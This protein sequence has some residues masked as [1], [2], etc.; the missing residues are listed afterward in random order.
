[1]MGGVAFC[2]AVLYRY[3]GSVFGIRKPKYALWLGRGRRRRA[4]LFLRGLLRG[5]KGLQKL[6]RC[7]LGLRR[8]QVD[9]N[10][11]NIGPKHGGS[12]FLRSVCVIG[13][14]GCIR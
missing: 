13:C 3:T 11:I 14:V 9:A 6:L 5:L 8:G 10:G 12:S 4:L 7:A 1:M 2:I